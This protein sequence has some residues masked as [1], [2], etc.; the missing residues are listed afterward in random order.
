MLQATAAVMGVLISMAAKVAGAAVVEVGVA[1]VRAAVAA[2]AVL[3]EARDMA[4]MTTQAAKGTIIVIDSCF[5][6]L[7]LPGGVC[8][9]QNRKVRARVE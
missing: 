4:A 6:P 7:S 9:T 3:T 5:V 2:Q 1:Q 8:S